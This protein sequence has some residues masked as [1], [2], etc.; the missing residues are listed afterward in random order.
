MQRPSNSELLRSSSR[1]LF[2]QDILRDDHSKSFWYN[3]F[4]IF[5]FLIPDCI[6]RCFGI[7]SKSSITA[8][9][10]KVALCAIIAMLCLILGFFTYG[11]NI[12]LCHGNNNF[13]YGKLKLKKN[14][15][16]A[17]GGIFYT[18]EYENSS[19]IYLGSKKCRKFSDMDILSTRDM[20]RVGDIYF[21]TADVLNRNFIIRDNKIFNPAVFLEYGGDDVFLE[22]MEKIK[23]GGNIDILDKNEKLCFED[24]C[25]MGR[26]NSKSYGCLI[27]DF[28]L[29]IS[30]V[31]IF[32]LI[33]V[34]FFLA[35]FYSFYRRNKKIYKND[36]PAVMLVTCYSE[37]EEGIR[38]TLDSLCNQDHKEKILVIVADGDVKGADNDISTPQIIKN[39]IEIDDRY[40]LEPMDYLSLAIGNKKHN[41][42]IVY[43]G[44]YRSKEKECKV[45]FIEKI[46]NP[47][48]INKRGNRG[49]RDSQV[50]IMGFFQKILYDERMT[51]LDID[52]YHKFRYL[53]S[54][55]KLT[56]YECLLMVDADTIVE[57]DALTCF[58]ST[59]LDDGKIMGVCGETTIINKFDSWVSM[60][61][62]FEYYIAHHQAK[63]FE[64][65]F[66]GV[67]CLPGCFSAY[68]IRVIEESV[69]YDDYIIDVLNEQE[70]EFNSGG[71]RNDNGNSNGSNNSNNNGNTANNNIITTYDT[72]NNI[73]TTTNHTINHTNHITTN[74][75]T[76]TTNNN[77]KTIK[78]KRRMCVP[79]VANTFILNGYSVTETNTLH[80]KNLLLLGEDRYLTTIM[81]KTFYRR[82]LV[83]IPKAK[84]GTLVP[85]SFKVL[86]S[87]RRRWIN[88][89]VHNLF[90]LIGVNKLCGTFCCSMQF[91][92]GIELFG[93]LTLP[94]AIFFT[95]VL[96]VSSI[97]KEPAWIP[98]IMLMGILGLPGI[99]VFM[100]TFQLSYL[101][102]IIVYIVSLPVWNFI[103]PS[104]A[105]W[106]FDDFTWGETRK[107]EGGD[108]HEMGEG[109]FDSSL[110]RLRHLEEC[111]EM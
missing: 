52:L 107:V 4:P 13:I 12:F 83:F 98:L 86:L 3:I 65:V 97:M 31:I 15:V 95:G 58:T 51:P 44:V 81:L 80:E 103:L 105:F 41:R 21:Y 69:S 30:T 36:M 60:I 5:T 22:K 72:N 57:E 53:N 94:V 82:K 62:V 49:K 59:F 64:S 71:D 43:P 55:L 75:N 84:C 70:Q 38:H 90:V 77:T 24:G 34:K 109:V 39:M 7:K 108:A 27:A 63:A 99:L 46:G 104:Y 89:T 6:L 48:E 56:D 93:T 76:H 67:T 17:N 25:Y 87:Q 68:R 14:Y 40:G 1:T 91:V 32:S 18:D 54:H 85:S 35:I 8:W 11:I 111:E 19:I 50:I 20:V 37:N 28:L 102:W 2:R 9:R 10:E 66:G 23:N 96:I 45:I 92:V 88:S 78:S 110:V 106:H 26:L 47:N 79:L 42:A 73:I 74:H 16:I 100:T 29:Y 101:F 33:L 61:Q